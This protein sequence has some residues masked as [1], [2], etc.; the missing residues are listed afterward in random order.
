M[1]FART[2]LLGTVVALA[3][4]GMMATSASAAP[5]EAPPGGSGTVTS[6][7]ANTSGD[8]DASKVT[9]HVWRNAPSYHPGHGGRAG[10]L[11]AGNNYFYCQ[12][13]AYT[14]EYGEYKNNW[15]LLTDDDK[16]NTDVWVPA[17]FIS[18]GDN[19]EAIAGVPKC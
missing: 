16:G 18:G 17:V 7:G 4:G 6:T 2:A 14:Y 3:S 15:W 9:K 11:F 13:K 10:T 12:T 5:A 1:T 8:V 19:F